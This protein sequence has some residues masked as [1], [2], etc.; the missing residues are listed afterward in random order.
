[1]RGVLLVFFA[2]S[3]CSSEAPNDAAATDNALTS[4][5]G[6]NCARVSSDAGGQ[7]GCT[8]TEC[9]VYGSGYVVP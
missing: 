8:A 2:V 5:N 3:G 6:A 9:K 4:Q 7:L 1:M